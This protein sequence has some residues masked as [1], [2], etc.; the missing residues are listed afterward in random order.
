MVER[1]GLR[2]AV[3]IPTPRFP[4]PMVAPFVDILQTL[5]RA[6][7][8]LFLLLLLLLLLLPEV[9]EMFTSTITMPNLFT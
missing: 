2:A 9:L 1:A 4:T 8:P 5:P 6:V 3:L 7:L